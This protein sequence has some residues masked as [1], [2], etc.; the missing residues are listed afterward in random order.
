MTTE[1]KE[2]AARVG[3]TKKAPATTKKVL[4]P[5]AKPAAKKPVKAVS[6]S[7]KKKT[8]KAPKVKMVRDSFTMPQ[9]EYE[10]IAKIKD[11]FR[12][13]GLPI[14]KSEVLRAGLKALSALNMA[15][16]KRTLAGLANAK[17]IRSNKP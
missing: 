6:T 11:A 17:A 2:V 7:A 3:A 9:N 13:A 10:E 12:K 15:Q 8:E 14:K 5:V 4:K 1:K 16:Q